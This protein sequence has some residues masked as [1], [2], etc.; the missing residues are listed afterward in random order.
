[1]TSYEYATP[2]AAAP[3]GSTALAVRDP[4]AKTSL[5]LA[6]SAGFLREASEMVPVSVI[7]RRV[8]LRSLFK[9]SH[10]R[11]CDARDLKCRADEGVFSMLLLLATTASGVFGGGFL[12]ASIP[13]LALAL[14]GVG[15]ILG[16]GVA[17]VLVQWRATFCGIAPAVFR[18]RVA[19]LDTETLVLLEDSAEV[20][21]CPAT[22][23]LLSRILA[24]RAVPCEPVR[25]SMQAVIA[26]APQPVPESRL[27]IQ[28]VV[29]LSASDSR[30]A[31][32]GEKL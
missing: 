7:S 1:M 29:A 17:M 24:E 11:I 25:P 16:A 19:P 4:S 15:G 21:N 23:V 28:G 12:G 5:D 10:L 20:Q 26:T 8:G 31:E 2:Q 27:L 30:L 32:A 14:A 13:L 3:S 6:L 22:Q 9:A 18:A